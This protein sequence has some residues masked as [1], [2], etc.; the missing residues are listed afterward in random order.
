MAEKTRPMIISF[1]SGRLNDIM[2]FISVHSPCFCVSSVL[3]F[4]KATL[5]A[6]FCV[7]VRRSLA[8]MLSSGSAT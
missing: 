7:D 2:S 4:C 5:D 6:D 1:H 8:A 3:R